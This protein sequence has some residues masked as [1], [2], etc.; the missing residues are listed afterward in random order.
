[1]EN[2]KSHKQYRHTN[3]EQE[4]ETGEMVEREKNTHTRSLYSMN[5][6]QKMKIDP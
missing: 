6:T 2:D 1:M 5:A 3:S 4:T